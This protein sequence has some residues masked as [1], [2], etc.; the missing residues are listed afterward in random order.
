MLERIQG[1]KLLT[2]FVARDQRKSLLEI[3]SQVR[4]LTDLIDRFYTLLGPRHWI[5][6]DSLN[7]E[8]IK[9]L[10]GLSVDEAEQEFV[11]LYQDPEALR[12]MIMGLRRFPEMRSRMDLIEKARIDYGAG[13]FYATVL[14]L[15]TVMDGFVN[16]LQPEQRRGLH[17]RDAEELSAWDSVVGHHLGLTHAHKTFTKRTSKTSDEPVS[18][19]H[20]NGIIHGTLVN[21]DNAIVATKAWN[22]LFAVGDWAASVEKQKVKPV[23]NPTWREIFSQIAANEKA[24]KALEAWR[25]SSLDADDPGFADQDVCQRALAYLAG[26]TA[27]NYGVMALLISPGLGENTPRKTA[28]MIR[29][30]CSMYELRKFT[31]KRAVFDAPAVCEIN[32]D[33]TFDSGTHPAQMRWIREAV[34]GMAATPNVEGEWFLYLW[35]PWAMLNRGGDSQASI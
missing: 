33:L 6:H 29:D 27:K 1:M 34:D 10:I 9:A 13:R 12:F 24:K 25:P 3:E 7:T 22:R 21:Y 8:K 23:P 28:G 31:M 30:A 16:D 19:L 11:E 2:R 14:V 20:R 5:F 18:E 35:G 17:T 4:E 26:W 32:V 15:L